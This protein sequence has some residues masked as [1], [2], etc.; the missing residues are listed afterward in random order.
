LTQLQGQLREQGK[1]WLIVH[2]CWRRKQNRIVGIRCVKTTG[3]A[4]QKK[5]R[6]LSRR[7][8]KLLKA[9]LETGEIILTSVI[10]VSSAIGVTFISER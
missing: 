8:I 9:G 10:E 4:F 7:Q 3:M 1:L 2:R 5:K 6:W